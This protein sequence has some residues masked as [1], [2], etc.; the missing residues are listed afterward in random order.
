MGQS[1]AIY[2]L[3][4]SFDKWAQHTWKAT[5]RYNALDDITSN[6]FIRKSSLSH[7]T[8]HFIRVSG[9][10]M[11]SAFCIVGAVE[12]A[13]TANLIGIDVATNTLCSESIVGDCI[14]HFVRVSGVEV[15]FS[16]GAV[17]TIQG[18]EAR[19][20]VWED[21][22]YLAFQGEAVI[23]DGIIYFWNAGGIKMVWSAGAEEAK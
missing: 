12:R 15:I 21:T 2:R 22:T 8:I 3:G 6:S 14:A 18:D 20:R 23:L 7:H 16:T 9:I 5:I 13:R 1:K 19:L 11:I 10:E 4:D 17:C